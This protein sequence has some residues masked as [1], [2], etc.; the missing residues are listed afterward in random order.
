MQVII[1]GWSVGLACLSAAVIYFLI[2]YSKTKVLFRKKFPMMAVGA[3]GGLVGVASVLI[4]A[5]P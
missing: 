2:D 5:Q 4:G 3:V 1:I